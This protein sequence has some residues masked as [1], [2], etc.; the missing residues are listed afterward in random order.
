MKFLSAIL[1]VAIILLTPPATAS[2]G[3]SIV[4]ITWRGMTPA[5]QGFLSKLSELGVEA[6]YEHF[7]AGRDETKLAGYLRE[8]RDHLSKID[9]IYTFGTTVSVTVQNF[10][11]G[12]VPQVFNIVSDPLGSGLTESIAQ[13]TKGATGAK[14]SVSAE[15]ILQLLEKIYPFASIAILFDPQE[16]NAYH[17]AEKVM[18]AAEA[19]G[20]KAIRYRLIPDNKDV[21]EQIA[22]LRPQLEKSDVVYVAST[23]S[24]VAHT[25][26]MRLVIPEETVSVSS[27]PAFV[28]RGTT[29]AFGDEYWDRGEAAA[30]IAVQILENGKR[31]NEVSI[32]EITAD[33]ATIFIRD[34]SPAKDKLDIK[35]IKNEITYR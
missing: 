12:N 10:D 11:F 1:T 31:P 17:E 21:E 26:L 20:K 3:K 35:N 7:D 8:N 34:T 2:D 22:S 27:S 25:N 18:I 30:E 33:E 14:M 16:T 32:D 19:I 6:K 9:L 29:V 4:L 5:E 15:V 13:P 28:E 24:F 23:S